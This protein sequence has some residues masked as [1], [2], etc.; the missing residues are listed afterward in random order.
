MDVVG[1]ASYLDFLYS[2]PAIYFVLIWALFWRG[3]GLWHAGK[4]GQKYW[5]LAMFVL[6]TVGILPI[7]YLFIFSKTPLSKQ[8]KEIF[9]PTKKQGKKKSR[10]STS[11]KKR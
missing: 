6:N 1:M 11:K 4:N 10:R 3:L 5:F 9:R 7:I 2:E 8:C